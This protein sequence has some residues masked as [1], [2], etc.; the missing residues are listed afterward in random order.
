[1]KLALIAATAAFAIL[2]SIAAP[3]SSPAQA[4][5]SSGTAPR[6][7]QVRDIRNHTVISD[8]EILF[9]MGR[10]VVW[11]NTLRAECHGLKFENGFAWEIS[12]GEAC[13][14]Q[15]TIFVLNRGN[16]CQ[17]GEFSRYEAPP[18]S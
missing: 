11:K 6:C 18:R 9:D 12:G 1:M 14:N 4:A 8:H 3:A 10:H 17:L 15:Q 7:L 13:A 16:P 2:A 5:A